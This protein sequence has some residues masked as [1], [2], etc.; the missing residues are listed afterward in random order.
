[1]LPRRATCT[2]ALLLLAC[3]SP[4]RSHAGWPADGLPVCT[5]P[6]EQG[7][8]AMAPDGAG[9]AFTAWV[10][11]RSGYNADAVLQRVDALGNIAPGWSGNGEFAT[12]YGTA[13]YA[14]QAIPDGGGGV[15]LV[16]EDRTWS[17]SPLDIKLQRV[18][19]LGDVAAP[20]P[21][22]GVFVCAAAGDQQLPRLAPDGAGG[23]YV[24]WQDGRS[25][26]PRIYAS[27]MDAD[28]TLASGW[29][30]DGRALCPIPATQL[31]PAA[32]ADDSGGLYVAWEDQRFGN[33][34]IYLLRLTAD[35]VPAAG[36]NSGGLAACIAG[37]AQRRPLLA[38]DG[39][40]GV[41]VSWLDARTGDD[42]LYALR[43][44]ADGTRAPG[45]SSG[46]LP[47]C[48]VAGAQSAP[49]MV[50]DLEGGAFFAW[51]DA[52]DA[53]AGPRVFAQHLLG[54]GNIAWS[55]GG[56]PVSS[57]GGHQLGPRLGLDGTGGI[58]LAWSDRRDSAVTGWDVWSQRLLASGAK[59]W[60]GE[61]VPRCR[62][63]GD[64]HSVAMTGDGL[65]GVF[66]A[67]LDERALAGTGRDV[68]LARVGH[69]GAEPGQAEGIA[70]LHHDGQTFL[71]WSQ[72]KG[73]AATYRVYASEQPILTEDDL[74]A[75]AM[76]A[77]LG[78]SSACD[79]RLSQ[80]TGVTWGFVPDSGGAALDPAAGLFVVTA[81]KDRHVHY[82]V[83][84]QPIGHPENR[85][86]SP[87]ANTLVE[88]I[89][90]WIG[91]PRPVHQRAINVRGHWSQIY[92][93]WTWHRDTPL[94]PAM[95]NRPGL[96]FD[97]AVVAGGAAPNHPLMVRPH[98]RTG[99]FLQCVESTG[100]P[101]EWRLAL[102]DELPNRENTF[103]YGYHE[104]YDVTESQHPVPGSGVVVD[105]TLR[106]V[107]H[108]IEWARRTFPVDPNRVYTHGY[109]MAGMG[110]ML[111]LLRRPEWFA[112]QQS[113]VAK[114]DFSDL[115][116][117]NPACNFNPGGQLRLIAD[118]LWG[119]VATN[120]PSSEGGGVF[121]R[122][123]AVEWLDTTPGLELPPIMSFVGRMDDIV[124]WSEKVAFFA[125]MQRHRQCGQF[126][127]DMRNH[128]GNTTAPWSPM[129]SSGHLIPWRRDVS[130]PALTR[131]SADDDPGNGGI[132]DGDSVGT[133]NG[134]LTW[135]STLVDLPERWEVV[136][137]LRD[138]ALLTGTRPAPDSVTVDVT[139]RR[140]QRMRLDPGVV[141]RWFVERLP[142]GA[143]IQQ[144]STL[145]DSLGLVTA[146]QVRVLRAGVRVRF[147]TEVH[148]GVDGP[149]APG[150]AWTALPNPLARTAG[151]SV[152]WPRPGTAR[153]VLL[154][155]TGRRV[156]VLHDGPVEPG[157]LRLA[158]D[159]VRHAPGVYLLVAESHGERLTRRIAILR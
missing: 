136:L 150:L 107:L 143:P 113:L 85:T 29:P 95:A 46:G 140:L 31:A 16:W 145:A 17:S 142:D 81:E 37:G 4:A 51:E 117:A 44:A 138:L 66:L 97:C 12:L 87:G 127:W 83:T 144:G 96:P 2:L 75:A 153:V 148:L 64:Q 48:T 131:C 55:P 1:M 146:P 80:L 13:K 33:T 26:A 58:Y 65:G 50:G 59:G 120:L 84:M 103:W 42:D 32:C 123:D 11:P 132:L 137:R 8:L 28:S 52:R 6:G 36:W 74:E 49:A 20:W 125:A 94:F 71:M 24:V 141:V 79:R 126:F 39:A 90:E 7:A 134:F 30:L 78:D 159:P 62:A 35:G 43:V 155:V 25:G 14:L 115:A 5:A 45:W 158:L 54:D 89:D 61:G 104:N 21:R 40:G 88:G 108:T 15:Y 53:V 116:D 56:V 151:F 102:D 47:V 122:L 9:G 60:P 68:Y 119:A 41:L 114:Y 111:L 3:F 147:E 109:S 86:L 34:D 92:T 154:D 22:S 57:G 129:Q 133:I 73:T 105:Y 124:G 98:A 67:W 99:N 72:P 152:R 100:L 106:R 70:A 157:E 101:G 76:I 149:E 156:E 93:L 19:S 69:D 118:Q 128:I 121:D 91:L 112:A 10:D 63:I 139:P 135:D 23:V 27:R 38:P 77:V 130:F 110:G 82:A 18:T